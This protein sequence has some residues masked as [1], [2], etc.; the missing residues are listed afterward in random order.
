VVQVAAARA[1]DVG[2]D[3]QGLADQHGV[4]DGQ[5][6][7]STGDRAG[8]HV[9]VLA[10]LAVRVL[11]PDVVVV[12]LAQPDHDAVGDAGVE[13]AVEVEVLAGV[14]D[15]VGVDVLARVLA[16]VL[17]R[18]R[19]HGHAV[20]EQLTGLPVEV[21]PVTEV[22]GIAVD[23]DDR[24][25]DARRRGDDGGRCR[26]GDHVD[27][28]VA[29][30]VAR[31]AAVVVVVAGHHHRRAI[32]VRNPVGRHGHREGAVARAGRYDGHGSDE[33]PD[34]QRR[35]DHHALANLSGVHRQPPCWAANPSGTG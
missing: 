28:V 9:G 20:A 5:V 17:E 35:A 15:A 24:H 18:V 7:R 1:A 4:A 27:P 6:A 13:V 10:P 3:P 12:V 22:A 16:A 2:L 26:V 8:R 23:V 14:E 32:G 25:D 29:L 30:V 21:E 11:D 33:R 31:G 34:E 19:V